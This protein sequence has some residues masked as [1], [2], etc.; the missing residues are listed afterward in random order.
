MKLLV[1]DAQGT[2]C[3]NTL[4]DPSQWFVITLLTNNIFKNFLT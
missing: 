4:T 1:S 3:D 2:R